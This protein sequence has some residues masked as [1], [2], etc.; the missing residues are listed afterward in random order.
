MLN[1][2]RADFY[3]LL[4]SK[5]FYIAQAV[6]F[7]FVILV[8]STKSIGIIGIVTNQVLDAQDALISITWNAE[9]G[10][11]NISTMATSL[12]YILIP[13]F[14]LTLGFDFS[15]KTYKNVLPMG[16]SRTTY[17]LSKYTT[18]IL[19]SIFEFIIYYSITFLLSFLL[20]GLGD[21]NID[22]I[23]DLFKCI[24]LQLLMTN[25]I[26]AV[27]TLVLFT[28]L[29][30]IASVITTILFPLIASIVAEVLPSL[31]WVNY[32]NFQGIIDS[33]FVINI[34]YHDIHM[35]ILWGISVII[36][37]TIISLIS[38]RKRQL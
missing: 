16:I 38:F 1:I 23:F 33:L 26:F 32:F 35:F 24:S 29:S 13:A 4:H 11:R 27:S 2:M 15:E 3:R 22:F 8:V 7:T 17:F 34:P 36:L 9:L 30:N 5:G 25:G 10:I 14:V 6:L 21:I 12:I 20:Y 18:F 28:S 19:I 31:K 37:S